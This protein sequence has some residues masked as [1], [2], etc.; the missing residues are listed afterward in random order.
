MQHMMATTTPIWLDI[1][2]SADWRPIQ[3]H[4]VSAPSLSS[5]ARLA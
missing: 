3:T 5:E 1:V 4:R 2:G